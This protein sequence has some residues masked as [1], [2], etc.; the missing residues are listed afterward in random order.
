MS[1]GTPTIIYN[2]NTLVPSPVPNTAALVVLRIPV[3]AAG[4]SYPAGGEPIEL[5]VTAATAALRLFQEI[6]SFA[7]ELAADFVTAGVG[8]DAIGAM[9]PVYQP[10]ALN[11]TSGAIRFY[12]G[13]GAGANL[14][15]LVVG[16]YPNNLQFTAT[17]IGRPITDAS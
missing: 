7:I 1:L 4:N 9:A 10:S 8:A 3:V 12:Q 6:F 2:S 13:G 14:A 5:G 17:I 11:A 16:Q 15:E